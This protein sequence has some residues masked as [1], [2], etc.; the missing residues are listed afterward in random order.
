[1]T[2]CPY[3]F[4]PASDSLSKEYRYLF[5]NKSHF[6]AAERRFIANISQKLDLQAML[7]C[8]QAIVGTHDFC[9]FVST[10]SNVKSTLRT[11]NICELAEIN[12]HRLFAGSRL[13]SVPDSLTHCYELRIEADGFLKQ[14]IRHLVRSL[15]MV[16]SGK[17]TTEQFLTLLNGPKVAKQ[18][19][20]VAPASGLYLY[21]IKYRF[22]SA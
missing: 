18:L 5:T 12:P 14:M 1:M 3:E 7:P 15:W 2:P 21:D 16:G 4:R 17:I 8:V 10:G 11:V 19:W 22:F 6:S 20:R 9:N 13:F